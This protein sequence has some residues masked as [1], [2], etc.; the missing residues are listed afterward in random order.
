MT[1]RIRESS[2]KR[3]QQESNLLP[4]RRNVRTPKGVE[5]TPPEPLAQTL[6]CES[7]KAHSEAPST[8]RPATLD[9]A[10]VAAALTELPEADR[11]ARLDALADA[12]RPILALTDRVALAARLLDGGAGGRG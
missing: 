10:T 4:I 3:R 8:S 5:E 2:G 9:L 1:A 12:L 11:R 6:A 7:E